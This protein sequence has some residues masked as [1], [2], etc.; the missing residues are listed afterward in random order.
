MATRISPG[1]MSIKRVRGH[2]VGSNHFLTKTN[3][4]L[5]NEFCAWCHF[6]KIWNCDRYSEDHCFQ[7]DSVIWR[8]SC[9]RDNRLSEIFCSEGSGTALR[10]DLT[11]KCPGVRVDMS[12]GSSE[13]ALNERELRISSICT[14]SIVI[15]SYMNTAWSMT[16]RWFD[17]FH[18]SF[19][20]FAE[21]WNRRWIEFPL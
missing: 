6:E 3:A 17:G 10:A 1:C 8:K 4:P 19:P 16:R 18:S 21:V 5:Q 14:K 2:L 15:S 13:R 20:F 9:Q 11:R 7:N 12:D